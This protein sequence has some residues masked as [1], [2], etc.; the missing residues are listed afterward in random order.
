VPAVSRTSLVATLAAAVLTAGCGADAPA[1]SNAAPPAAL[2]AAA[3]PYLDSRASA[4][5]ASGIAHEAQLPDLAGRLAGWGFEAGARRYFQ[6]QSKRLQVVDARS[7]R[8]RDA[9]GASAFVGYFGDHAP[10]FFG[11]AGP[12]KAFASRGRHGVVV[13]GAPCACHLATPSY[14][15]VVADG[16]LVTWVEINGPRASLKALHSLAD[17]AP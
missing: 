9:A 11:G 6:G 16:P 17:R 2:P 5:S 7:L 10:S 4:L 14:L 15:G 1:Q 13:E 3:V 8:F 12:P